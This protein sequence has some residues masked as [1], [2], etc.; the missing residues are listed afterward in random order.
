MLLYRAV[1]CV[2]KWQYKLNGTKMNKL[3]TIVLATM[4]ILSLG[5][6]LAS[7]YSS[8]GADCNFSKGVP[9]RDMPLACQPGN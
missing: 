6:C 9:L 7:T 2:S 5:G 3:A 4:M 1:F 8:V